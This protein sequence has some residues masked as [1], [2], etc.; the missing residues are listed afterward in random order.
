MLFLGAL[1]ALSG[2]TTMKTPETAAAGKNRP[3]DFPCLSYTLPCGSLGTREPVEAKLTGELD[4]D[5]E[6]GRQIAFALNRGNC[7]ACHALK[8]G[9]QAGTRGPD[10]SQYGRLGKGDD[11]IYSY[12]Y[13]PRLRFPDTVMPPMGTNGILTEREIRDVVAYLQQSR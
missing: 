3:A 9:E 7:I 12:I 6:A 1:L 8:G 4:G 11:E 13:E 10:L 2:C 5:P